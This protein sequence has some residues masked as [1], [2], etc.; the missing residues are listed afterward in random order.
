MAFRCSSLLGF[1]LAL[2]LSILG[3]QST[4]QAAQDWSER[5]DNFRAA[6]LAGNAKKAASIGDS[7]ID[8]AAQDL[9]HHNPEFGRLALEVG[10]AHH[11]AGNF[12]RAA[13]L[14]GK[15]QAAFQFALGYD[16]RE[17]FDALVLMADIALDAEDYDAALTLFQESLVIALLGKFDGDIPSLLKG[18]AQTYDE[19]DPRIAETIRTSDLY[20]TPAAETE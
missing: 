7:F 15:A 11:R 5:Y 8:D 14:V 17:T 6:V 18:L 20:P 9:N 19:I 13:T 12:D 16:D 10:S 1:V 3:A 2:G 4:A